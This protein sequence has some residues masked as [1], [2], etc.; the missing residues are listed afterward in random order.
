VVASRIGF[1]LGTTLYLY[2]SGW[3][4]RFAQYSVMTT[5]LAE[6]IQH[7]IGRGLSTVHLSTGKDVA[8]TRW[9]PREV[10]YVSGVELAP[11]RSARVMYAGYEAVMRLGAAG[12]ARFLTPPFLVRRST[13]LLSE[14]PR[15]SVQHLQRFHAVAVGV[16]VVLVLD[17]FDGVIDGTI[18]FLLPELG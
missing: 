6:T 11:R 8:K 14:P 3:D 9:G 5:L 12:I 1:E 17:L 7:A 18:R 10:S 2:Y 15:L 4:T 16:A 13:P